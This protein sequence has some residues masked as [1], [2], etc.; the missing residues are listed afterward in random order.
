MQLVPDRAGPRA[1][2]GRP[3]PRARD[4]ARAPRERVA[5]D[6]VSGEVGH[7]QSVVKVLAQERQHATDRALP[8]GAE[9]G[10]LLGA[11]EGDELPHRHRPDV[12]GLLQLRGLPREGLREPDGM[13]P[14]GRAEALAVLL[15][16]PEPD[17]AVDRTPAL[18]QP[19]GDAVDLNGLRPGLFRAGHRVRGAG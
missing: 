11:V 2:F 6:P 14:V 16:C 3:V 12:A 4:R 18:V 8:G 15:P 1:W 10:Q 9:R 7:G 19:H 5:V 17:L 13:R